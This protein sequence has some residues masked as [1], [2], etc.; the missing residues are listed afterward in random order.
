[1]QA[2]RSLVWTSRFLAYPATTACGGGPLPFR[3]ET[4]ENPT[5]ALADFCAAFAYYSAANNCSAP[6]RS[7]DT[8]RLT[9]RSTMV[10]PNK[11]CMRDMVT[12]LW[13][14]IR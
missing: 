7:T 8:R 10:T 5:G 13:V 9:P 14:T 2:K 12:A 6:P 11:R 1:M 3:E 4:R